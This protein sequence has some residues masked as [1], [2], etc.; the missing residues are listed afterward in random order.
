MVRALDEMTADLPPTDPYAGIA[1]FAPTAEQLRRIVVKEE[2]TWRARGGGR[3]LQRMKTAE[4]VRIP[5][6]FKGTF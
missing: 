5:E 1:E 2:D 4:L 3:Q 6:R